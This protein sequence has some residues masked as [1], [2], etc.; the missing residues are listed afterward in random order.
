MKQLENLGLSKL[1]IKVFKAFSKDNALYIS[2][3]AQKL[4]TSAPALYRAV[5][6]LEKLG[7]IVQ[8][9][10]YPKLYQARPLDSAL[11]NYMLYQRNLV[12]KI[13][14]KTTLGSFDSMQVLTGRSEILNTYMTLASEAQHS[15]LTISIGEKMPDDLYD[16]KAKLI[17]NGIKNYLIF[18]QHDNKNDIWLK[19]WQAIGSQVKLLPGSGYHLNIIDFDYAILSSS[20]Q[21]DTNVRTAVL[22]NNQN[23]VAELRGYFIQQW[24]QAQRLKPLS[25]S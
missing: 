11:E 1:E 6:R 22:I 7:F 18:Q 25:S 13:K 20:S 12:S 15:L 21:Q 5:N 16:L 8:I 3:I 2:D 23:I 17:K 9:G 19:R 24:Q 14:G 10:G 4:R